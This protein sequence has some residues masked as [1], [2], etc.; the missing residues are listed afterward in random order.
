MSQ[1]VVQPVAARSAVLSLLLGSH[2]PTLSARHLVHAMGLVGIS[3]STTRVALSRMVSAGDLV[4]DDGR[5]TL[6]DRLLERQ[7][8]QDAVHAPAT[9]QW[10]GTWEMAVV[11]TS[12]RS[13]QDRAALRAQMVAMR[14]AELRE[15]VWT[16]P[17]NLRRPWPPELLAVSTCFEARAL[18]DSRALAAR[19]WD[20]D[21][22]AADGRALLRLLQTVE[23][24]AE[25]FATMVTAVRHLQ[26][27]PMLPAELEP[28]AWPGDQLRAAYDDYRAWLVSM[29]PQ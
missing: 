24:P 7:A 21:G 6:S 16:R 10:P 2:P 26:S 8:R 9:R 15:G 4:R 23:D 25:R 27:D 29:R 12:G 17:A 19:L 14:V 11:T 5:Y 1:P 22:W 28:E 13:P 20:L 18:E 3:E